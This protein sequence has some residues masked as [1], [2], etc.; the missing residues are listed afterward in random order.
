[1]VSARESIQ[2]LGH[3]MTKGGHPKFA[4]VCA[5]VALGLKHSEIAE[6]KQVEIWE[7]LIELSQRAPTETA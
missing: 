7:L 1:M 4:A 2:I 6:P 3:H 5:L